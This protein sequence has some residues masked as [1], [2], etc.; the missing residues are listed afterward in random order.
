MTIA[1]ALTAE[2]ERQGLSLYKL[3]QDAG[4]SVA[5]VKSILDG[6]TINPG[7]LTVRA[8]LAAMGKSLAWLER[9]LKK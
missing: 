5:R 2:R 3:A 8:I 6:E 4:T 1:E 7:I 9:E